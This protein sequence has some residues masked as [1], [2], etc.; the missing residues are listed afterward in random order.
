MMQAAAEAAKDARKAS[1]AAG[2]GAADD[3]A[4][5]EEEESSSDYD[6]DE[7]LDADD[8]TDKVCKMAAGP[9]QQG[10]TGADIAHQQRLYSSPHAVHSSTAAS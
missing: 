2:A 7:D 3:D 6:D 8:D 10:C 5:D 4:Y 9:A 1:G